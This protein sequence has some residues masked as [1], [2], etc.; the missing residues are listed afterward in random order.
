MCRD[1]V[2][3]VPAAPM[4]TIHAAAHH[5]K[6]NDPNAPGHPAPGSLRATHLLRAA[7]QV[8]SLS[9]PP[10]DPPAS[11]PPPPPAPRPLTQAALGHSRLLRPWCCRPSQESCRHQSGT[12]RGRRARHP[13][14][15][16]PLTIVEAPWAA[17]TP[18][19]PRR[20]R[21]ARWRAR[22][23]PTRWPRHPQPAA[24]AP[25]A[26]AAR[27]PRRRL[28]VRSRRPWETA[29]HLPARR[30]RPRTAGAPGGGGGGRQR[31]PPPSS[32]PRPPRSWRRP[33]RRRVARA[34]RPRT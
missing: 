8:P 24:P 18:A 9:A 14:H 15:P 32:P 30:C 23:S 7:R 20:S 21:P 29:R 16:L 3:C 26:A 31:R 19:P 5:S 12:P 2:P 17:A 13:R 11:R 4:P 6:A 34:A 10:A 27:A 33:C 22:P 28:R 1:P 25:P